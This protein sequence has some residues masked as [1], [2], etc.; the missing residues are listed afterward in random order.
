MKNIKLSIICLTYNHAKFIRQALDGFVMQKTTFPF[1]VIIHDDASTDETA[2]I[3]REFE[4]KYPDIIKPIYQVENQWNKKNIWKE[5]VFPLVKGEY[6]A[7]CEG[8]DY[9]TDENKLQKQVDFLEAHPDYSICFHPVSVKYEDKSRPDEIFPSDNLLNELGDTSFDSLLRCNFIQTNSVMYR[10]RFHKDSLSLLPDYIQPGD[11]FLHLLHAQVGKI[12]FLPDVMAVYRKHSGGIWY[13]AGKSDLHYVNN[14][15][16]HLNFIAKVREQFG[17]YNEQYSLN[18][19]QNT[20]L[21][22][23]NHKEFEK[24]K[25]FSQWFPEFYTEAVKYTSDKIEAY[26]NAEAMKR[27]KQHKWR[28][29]CGKIVKQ[30]K[31][32][33]YFLYLPIIKLRHPKQ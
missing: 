15:L 22:L 4:A 20:L 27:H 21:A 9:W 23:L 7:L 19:A 14:G 28:K 32:T 16:P 29:L 2:D 30:H 1:E 11:W 26:Q 6:V 31:T 25:Q 5:I 33:Y 18:F 3:I 24:L 13:N 12:G 10:W 8:D 17:Y